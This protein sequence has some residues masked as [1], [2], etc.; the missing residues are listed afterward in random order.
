MLQYNDLEDNT[1][2]LNWRHRLEELWTCRRR[3]PLRRRRCWIDP[4]V[5]TPHQ[6]KLLLFS[7]L[8]SILGIVLL[9]CRNSFIAMFIMN[10]SD[11][12]ALVC[13]AAL[14]GSINPSIYQAEKQARR[15]W[16]GLIKIV[17]LQYTS[18]HPILLQYRRIH[19]AS[20][21]LGQNYSGAL[22][23]PILH[24]ETSRPQARVDDDESSSSLV[25]AAPIITFNRIAL[26]EILTSW[27]T[28]TL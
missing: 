14:K 21:I 20:Q 8:R 26:H 1:L 5:K 19:R 16:R 25:I 12:A 11:L 28:G 23:R 24:G 13:V 22:T 3:S 9:I 6:T 18:R 10:I 4:V 2:Q 27:F 17:A 15:T 7:S